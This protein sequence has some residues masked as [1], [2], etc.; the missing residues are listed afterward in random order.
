MRLDLVARMMP[1]T[2]YCNYNH[3]AAL[4]QTDRRCIKDYVEKGMPI[5]SEGF[6]EPFS[7]REWVIANIARGIPTPEIPEDFEYQMRTDRERAIIKEYGEDAKRYLENK[8][9]GLD[10]PLFRA[11]S[12]KGPS[13]AEKQQKEKRP[14]RAPAK[15]HGQPNTPPTSVAAHDRNIIQTG[16]DD[17]DDDDS[18]SSAAN[19]Q[20]DDVNS[21]SFGNLLSLAEIKR[22]HEIEKAKRTALRLKIESGDYVSISKVKSQVSDRARYERDSWLSWAMRSAPVIAGELMV[23]RSSVFPIIDRLVREHLISLSETPVADLIKQEE[24]EPDQ[25][26]IEEDD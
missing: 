1:P 14:Y 20:S 11:A 25:D 21:P 3:F 23:D 24:Y 2:G 15:P 7:A 17:D 22:I 13:A 18:N 10:P 8:E 4:I 6:I 26:E 5:S 16:L 9:A 12:K 19:S